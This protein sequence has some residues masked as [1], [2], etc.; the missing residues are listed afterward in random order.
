M[1]SRH[2]MPNT[3]NHPAPKTKTASSTSTSSTSDAI[4]S[5]FT[6]APSY[7]IMHSSTSRYPL[8][9]AHATESKQATTDTS[10]NEHRD[11]QAQ[12]QTQ[13]QAGVRSS[14]DSWDT[15]DRF[16]EEQERRG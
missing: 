5:F 7:P 4:K 1:A 8:P 10:R 11:T 13:T 2:P 6:I 15:I 14:E 12:T 9:T 16:K 3:Y